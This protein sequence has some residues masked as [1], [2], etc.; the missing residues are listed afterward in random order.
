MARA[1]PASPTG[2]TRPRFPSGSAV[3]HANYAEA[4]ACRGA[5]GSRRP[6]AFAFLRILGVRRIV[7]VSAIVS[8]RD[9]GDLLTGGH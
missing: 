1:G 7:G 2:R 6:T 3:A 9:P 8:M 5:T 4:D